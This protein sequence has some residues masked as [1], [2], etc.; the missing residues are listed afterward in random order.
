[1]LLVHAIGQ[2]RSRRLVDDAHHL[3]P[4]DATRILGRLALRIIK[5]SGHRDDGL[6]DRLAQ[7]SF[8]IGL[9]LG[10][11]HG[12]DLSRRVLLA[13]HHHPGIPICG[14]YDLVRQDL[15]GL[16]H[17]WVR[18]LAPHQPLDGKDCILRVGDGLATSDLTHQTLARL[19]VDR[20]Y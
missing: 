13:A 1:V 4:S 14:L 10:Q 18:V 15:D 5:V 12:R 16:L 19:G 20:H 7:V 11:N 9:E 8:R 3:K 6:R 2:R 17:L